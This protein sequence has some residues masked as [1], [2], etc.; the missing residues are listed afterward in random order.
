MLGWDCGRGIF[1]NMTLQ[2]YFK[3]NNNIKVEDICAYFRDGSPPYSFTIREALYRGGYTIESIIPVCINCLE[4]EL[5][6]DR[7]M[8]T[9]SKFY[10]QIQLKQILEKLNDKAQH[11]IKIYTDDSKETEI[12]NKIKYG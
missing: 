4:A 8:F 6:F 9:V 1:N 7:D 5:I 11:H 10:S 12:N 3:D 2:E